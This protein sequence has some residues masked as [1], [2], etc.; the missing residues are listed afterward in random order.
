LFCD[1][2]LYN[3]NNVKE[4]YEVLKVV[5]I[6]GG[7][8]PL[9]LGHLDHIKKAKMLGDRLV[10]ITH[11]D[12]ILIQKKGYYLLPL[13]HRVEILK[14]LKWV[15]KVIVSIDED[16]TVAKTLEEIRGITEGELIFAKGGDRT[17]DNMPQN[18]VETCE[19][20]GIKITYGVGNKLASSQD[21]AGNLIKQLRE[22][23]S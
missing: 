4:Y 8:D 14:A 18:E 16:G 11:P 21:I 1:I 6:A 20:L 22:V 15:D 5:I 7:F 2:I 10:A 23:F 12:A 17:P 19:K 3:S 9:H 13:A